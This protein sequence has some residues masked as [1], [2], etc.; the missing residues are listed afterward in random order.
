MEQKIK[1][2]V[3]DTWGGNLLNRQLRYADPSDTRGEERSYAA[4]TKGEKST[5]VLEAAALGGGTLRL[6]PEVII[7]RKTKKK[8]RKKKPKQVA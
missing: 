3:E 6:M 8:H 4:N 1:L 5:M 7:N 2:Q